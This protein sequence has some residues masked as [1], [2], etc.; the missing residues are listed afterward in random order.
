LFAT[1]GLRTAKAWSVIDVDT[2]DEA[3]TAFNLDHRSFDTA[4]ILELK[5]TDAA[6]A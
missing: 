6:Q 2:S 5:V 1:E 4:G 3:T